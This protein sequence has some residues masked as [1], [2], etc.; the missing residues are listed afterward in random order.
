MAPGTPRGTPRK[1]RKHHQ[2]TAV[3]HGVAASDYESDAPSSSTAQPATAA[4]P[5]INDL[6]VKVLRHYVPNMHS[7]SVLAIHTVVYMME[8]DGN[9]VET[10][11]GPLFVCDQDPFLLNQ[12]LVPRSSVFVMN[13]V[14]LENLMID[15]ANVDEMDVDRDTNFIMLNTSTVE[16]ESIIGLWI[17]DGKALRS[18]FSDIQNRWQASRPAT[19]Q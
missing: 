12:K 16:L 11:K 1:P 14:G 4:A 6:N 18:S 15:L 9:W 5:A 2:H 13:R 19:H 8:A 10:M 7:C 17:E 3:A